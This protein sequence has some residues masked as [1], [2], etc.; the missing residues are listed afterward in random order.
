MC[1]TLRP[2]RRQPTRLPRPWDSPGKNTG[3][4][5]RFLLQCT[6]VKTDSE[7][8]QS[9]RTLSD[10]MDCSPPGSSIHGIF[11]ARVLEWGAIAFSGVYSSSQNYFNILST[12]GVSLGCGLSYPAI[13]DNLCEFHT[14]FIGIIRFSPYFHMTHLCKKCRIYHNRTVTRTLIY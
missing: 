9:C 4:G 1:P 5:C 14:Y 12:V 2:H 10:P 8:T 13:R 7:V 11:Q 6:K 3:V